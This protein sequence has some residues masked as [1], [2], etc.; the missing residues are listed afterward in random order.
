MMRE[1]CLSKIFEILMLEKPPSEVKRLGEVY[2]I[3]QRIPAIG[4]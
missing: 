4:E 3:P 1:P 2:P